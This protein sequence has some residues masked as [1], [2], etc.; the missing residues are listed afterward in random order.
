MIKYKQMQNEKTDAIDEAKLNKFCELLI[1]NKGNATQAYLEAND[2]KHPGKKDIKGLNNIYVQASR[3]RSSEKCQARLKQMLEDNGLND[4]LV[5]GELL[6]LIT[7][8]DDLKTKKEAIKIYYDITSR[9]KRQ[10][11]ITSNGEK[12]TG[13]QIGFENFAKKEDK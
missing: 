2:L 10:I 5:D 1:K 6:G 13:L 9:T 11:D 4:V 7:Q 12:I 8:D 3:W